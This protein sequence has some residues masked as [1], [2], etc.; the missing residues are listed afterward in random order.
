MENSIV[1]S[2]GSKVLCFS[3][4]ICISVQHH[5]LPTCLL[6]TGGTVLR[7][8]KGEFH[9]PVIAVSHSVLDLSA[10]TDSKET[11]ECHTVLWPAS[12]TFSKVCTWLR[13]PHP[14]FKS[15]RLLREFKFHQKWVGLGLLNLLGILHFFLYTSDTALKLPIWFNKTDQII[16]TCTVADL[17][18]NK[19]WP[20]DEEV[21]ISLS[22][23]LSS[24]AISL[25]FKM[26]LVT[27]KLISASVF[28]PCPLSW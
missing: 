5:C 9:K 17:K 15:T 6:S 26:H 19:I 8:G 7:R 18:C 23:H 21:H 1:P 13:R 20:M 22:L 25:L 3:T 12:I 10:M 27:N 24:P 4:E 11:S 2:L 28:I 16:M 14:I